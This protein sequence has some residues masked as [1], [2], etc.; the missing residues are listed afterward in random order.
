[1]AARPSQNTELDNQ[2]G[3]RQKIW[4]GI[5]RAWSKTRIGI[6]R[7]LPKFLTSPRFTAS[8]AAFSAAALEILRRVKEEAWFADFLGLSSIV[9]LILT[10]IQ[11]VLCA[12]VWLFG[13]GAENAGA[14]LR[15]QEFIA[16]TAKI[17]RAK[18]HR[19]RAA[20]EVLRPTRRFEQITKPTVQID[21]I[22]SAVE[23][24][25]R[26]EFGL[27]ENQMDITILMSKGD[28]PWQ[29]FMQMQKGWN[30]GQPQQLFDRGSAAAFARQSGEPVFHPCKL[31]AARNGLFKLSKRDVDRKSGSAFIHPVKFNLPSGEY[32]EFIINIVT[33]G[34]RFCSPYDELAVEDT[35]IFLREITNRIELE[36]CLQAILQQKKTNDTTA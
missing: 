29:F 10:G 5:Q 19:F 6:S 26:K 27:R 9:M 7:W 1:M 12:I 2:I 15:A 31:E 34:K 24:F 17:V 11:L 8:F 28:Q 32:H 36:L 33:Y 3:T 20:L 13:D 14:D 25:F 23:G 21:I 4:L 16:A 30:H 18:A 35:E 22:M